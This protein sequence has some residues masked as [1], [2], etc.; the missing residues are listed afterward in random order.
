MR[1]FLFVFA[2]TGTVA[3]TPAVAQYARIRG[4]SWLHA[5]GYTAPGYTAPGYRWREQR[6]NE[7]QRTNPQHA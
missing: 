1:K 4:H 3:I 6:L 2:S 7:E 5:P